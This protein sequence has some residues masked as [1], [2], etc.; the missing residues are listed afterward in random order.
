MPGQVYRGGAADFSASW[1]DGTLFDRD[2]VTPLLTRRGTGW[3][4]GNQ[5]GPTWRAQGNVLLKGAS[6]AP[7][8]RTVQGQVLKGSSY[9]IL[10]R[11]VGDGITRANGREVV[12]RGPGLTP[13]ELLL[14]ALVFDKA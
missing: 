12:C 9:E 5:A 6:S 4:V 3:A 14:A 7:F 1:K 13:D 11:L 2:G 8:C 10:Y